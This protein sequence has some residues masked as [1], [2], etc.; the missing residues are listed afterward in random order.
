[1]TRPWDEYWRLTPEAAAHRGGGPQEEV[2]RRFWTAFFAETLTADSP[3]MLDVAC[4]NGA[5]SE[6][7]LEAASRAGRPLQIFG[8]DSSLAAMRGLARRLPSV[9]AVL[10]DVRRAPFADGSFHVV[11]SQ[12]G[13]EYAG[14][15]AM[16]EVAR[17]LAPGAVM[18]AVLHLKGG[19]LFRENVTNLE[20][21]SAVVA[22]G[23]LPALKELFHSHAALRTGRGSRPA[24]RRS[25]ETL[26]SACA[27]VASVIRAAGSSVAGGAVAR[28]HEDVSYLARRIDSHDAAEVARWADRALLEA[29]S[30]CG[31]MG[32]MVQAAVDEAGLEALVSR[33]EAGGL[34]VRRREKLLMG[35]R[36]EPAA[37]A[38][39]L[40]RARPE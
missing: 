7:A 24:F 25:E 20:A 11:A 33:A 10:G 6:M 22:S 4:G 8:L 19:A 21:M 26:A 17:L 9:Q 31:R 32:S 34:T 14:P 3:R 2:L 39:L 30:Y 18:G 27:S 37:W 29:E 16:C 13:L 28:L 12:F 40:A 36:A 15:G 23:A 5:V 1:M 38:L 35:A